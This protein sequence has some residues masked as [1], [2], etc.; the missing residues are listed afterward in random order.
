MFARTGCTPRIGLQNGDVLTALNAVEITSPEQALQV[1]DSM[2]TVN[3][4]TLAV[5]RDGKKLERS[6]RVR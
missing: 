5:D 6:F 4:F 1:F 2:T 3:R